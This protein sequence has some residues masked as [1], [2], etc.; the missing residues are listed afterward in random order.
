M[1]ILKRIICLILITIV[2]VNISLPNT[3]Y[4]TTIVDPLNNIG[5]SLLDGVFGFLTYPWKLY[6]LVPGLVAELVLTEISSV[7]SGDAQIIT[8]EKILF[9]E[10]ALTDINIFS[11]DTT[12]NGSGISGSLQE[13]RKGVAS[14]YYAFRNLA[15]AMAL[16]TLVYIGIRMAIT[17]IADEKAK[18]KKMLTNWIVRFWVN[19]YFTLFYDRCNKS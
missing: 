5:S 17:S 9:N 7:G 11:N 13:I 6:L 16:A 3:S 8:L 1:S 10:V 12:T 2:L 4:A 15:I 18:Y 14:W 19:I